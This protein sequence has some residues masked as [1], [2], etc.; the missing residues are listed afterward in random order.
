MKAIAR[1]LL[2]AILSIAASDL[3]AQL[4][5]LRWRELDRQAAAQA[6]EIGQQDTRLEA[7][8]A[9]QRELERQIEGSRAAHAEA[10]EAFNEVYRRVMEAG[11]AIARTEETIQNLRGRR[12]QLGGA[13]R[14]ERERLDAALA[15]A[16]SEDERL[17]DLSTRLTREEPRLSGLEEEGTGARTRFRAAEVNANFTTIP[18]KLKR[19]SVYSGPI[20]KMRNR[21][22]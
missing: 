8:V 3:Q 12:E 10:S 16:R 2:V 13:Q 15:Q 5:A 22:V 11:A 6:S 9:K 14:R 21:D 7:A 4:E 17:A 20:I 19:K 18:D 1:L